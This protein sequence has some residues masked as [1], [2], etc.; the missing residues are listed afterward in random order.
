MSKKI[1]IFHLYPDAMNL[2]GDLGNII[3]L[4]KR[5]EWRGFEAEVKNIHVGDTADFSKADILFMGGGQDSGQKIIV[6]DLIKRG[7]D[8]KEEINSGL[9][10][11]LVCGGFQLFGEYFLTANNEKIAGIGV[12]DAHTVASDKRLIGNVVA[13]VSHA[14]T[15][16]HSENP[17]LPNA[18]ETSTVVGFENHSGQ[19]VL[20]ESQMPFGTI[21]KGFGNEGS[22]GYEGAIYKNAIG[23]YL[24]GSLLPK[25]PAVADFLITMAIYRRYGVFEALPKLDDT[26]ENNAH[27]AAIK[28]AETAKS[29]SI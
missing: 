23:T 29:L 15:N 22:G 27:E 8:I 18:F 1:T 12:F 9:A 20:G 13:D 19:T 5:I 21:I 28:R 10:A 17:N 3:A 6:D 11:L 4:V 24:H 14:F 16:W 25:N 2:Y 7:A 26:V